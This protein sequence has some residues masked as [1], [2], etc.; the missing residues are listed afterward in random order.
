MCLEGKPETGGAAN[1]FLEKD[2]A[3]AIVQ[4]C[5]AILWQ[6]KLVVRPAPVT[7]Q[8]IEKPNFQQD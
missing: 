5:I 2:C 7:A 6:D 3:V 4:L 8:K 1:V